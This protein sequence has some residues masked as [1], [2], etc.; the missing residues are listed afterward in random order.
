MNREVNLRR[1]SMLSGVAAGLGVL[2]SPAVLRAQTP[3][4]M[5]IGTPTL[6]DAQHEWMRIFAREVEMHSNG[7]IKPELYPASQLGSA[8]R[9]IEGTQFGSIQCLVLPP[10]FLSGVD[11]RYEVLG[12][13]GLFQDLA[14]TNRGLQSPEFNRAF[15]AL[16][17]NRGLKGIG[18]FVNAMMSMNSRNPVEKLADI[19]GQKVRVL[20]SAMQTEQIRRLGGT[21]VP[22]PLGEVMPALQQGTIDGVLGSLPVL[23]A[24]R[25]YDSAKHVLRT[26][27]ASITVV[28]AVS[29]LWYDKLPK[30]LQTVIDQAGQKASVDVYDWAAKFNVQQE[31]V[32]KTNGGTV[33]TLSKAEHDSLMEMMRPIGAEVSSRRADVKALYD[34]LTRTATATA[35]A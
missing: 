32:W 31:Q 16:G 14:H 15:L 13:P 28:S 33:A 2:A 4:V 7:Q 8:P 17:A 30:P 35:T 1:R 12:A 29:K 21:A 9:M 22:M 34:L 24:M 6:N 10:E 25:F 11:S 20:A 3:M 26:E 23:A 19:R 18:L 5:K 27:H